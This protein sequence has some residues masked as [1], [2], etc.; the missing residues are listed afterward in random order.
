[1]HH[2]RHAYGTNPG[3]NDWYNAHVMFIIDK[4]TYSL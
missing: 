4:L 1:M 3:L 2:I